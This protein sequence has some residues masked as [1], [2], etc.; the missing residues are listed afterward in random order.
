MVFVHA[1][2]SRRKEINATLFNIAHSVIRNS[3]MEHGT[4]VA[5]KA[6]RTT[7]MRTNFYDFTRK[8]NKTNLFINCEWKLGVR[9]EAGVMEEVRRKRNDITIMMLDKIYWQLVLW[10]LLILNAYDDDVGKYWSCCE[11]LP[12]TGVPISKRNQLSTF[13]GNLI[14]QQQ[15]Q[16]EQYLWRKSEYTQPI[17]QYY[18]DR[19]NFGGERKNRW[20]YVTDK[21][22]LV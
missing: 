14:K 12:R 4:L 8:I 10:V 11:K 21:W 13:V 18:I 2:F 16:R 17:D 1:M 3:W 22:I 7:A 6:R 15:Q 9:S 20:N 5:K 19:W